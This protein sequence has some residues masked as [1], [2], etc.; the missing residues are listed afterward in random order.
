M[1]ND[2]HALGAETDRSP[3]ETAPAGDAG[4]KLGLIMSA[5]RDYHFALDNREHGDVAA[6][7]AMKSIQEAI[8]M[9]WVMG[10]EKSLRALPSVQGGE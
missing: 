6:D 10:K 9:P 8:G 4:N 2:R 7:K 5:I 3:A 1:Q